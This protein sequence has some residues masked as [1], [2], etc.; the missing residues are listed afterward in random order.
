M[1]GMGWQNGVELRQGNGTTVIALSINILK[2]IYIS[3][4]GSH[5]NLDKKKIQG[6]QIGI[7]KIELYLQII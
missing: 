5:E 1:G 6:I 4:P 2:N 7:K 3:F